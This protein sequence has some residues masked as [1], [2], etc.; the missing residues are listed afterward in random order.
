MHGTY[1]SPAEQAREIERRL[2]RGDDKIV[3]PPKFKSVAKVLWPIKTAA[4]LAA[5]AKTTERAAERWLSG[6]FEPPVSVVV[7]VI[8]E[9]F[10][11]E[12]WRMHN[13]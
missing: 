6:E 12:N 4:C 13:A 8:H 3:G 10:R 9:T 1:G 11:R 2:I 5:I 7:A